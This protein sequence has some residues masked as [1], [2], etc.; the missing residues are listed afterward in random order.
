MEQAQTH[1]SLAPLQFAL[2][3]ARRLLREA[4]IAMTALSPLILPTLDKQAGSMHSSYDGCLLPHGAH[5]REVALQSPPSEEAFL[6]RGKEALTAWAT[7]EGG[8]Q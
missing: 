6:W 2:L 7:N 1:K 3:P 5:T 4:S 8:S